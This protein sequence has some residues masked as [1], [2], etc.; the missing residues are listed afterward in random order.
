MT[1]SGWRQRR[2]PHVSP[3]FVACSN[4]LSL[5]SSLQS[6]LRWSRLVDRTDTFYS[7]RTSAVRV[8]LESA[9]SLFNRIRMFLWTVLVTTRGG[10]KGAIRVKSLNYR[11]IY[12]CIYCQ[13]LAEGTVIIVCSRCGVYCPLCLVISSYQAYCLQDVKCNRQSLLTRISDLRP[14]SSQIQACPILV[15]AEL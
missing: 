3:P 11:I 2:L 12:Y 10:I 13:Q 1:A 9:K 7:M 4:Q 6:S 15:S 8:I 5:Q 14:S